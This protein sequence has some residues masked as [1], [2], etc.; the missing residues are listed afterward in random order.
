MMKRIYVVCVPAAGAIIALGVVT[1]KPGNASPGPGGGGGDAGPDV[2]LCQL[3]D[4]TS[5]GRVGDI[6]AFSIRTDTWN[7]GAEDLSWQEFTSVH[8]LMAQNLYRF[9]DGRFEQI[10]LS[11]IKHGFCALQQDGCTDCFVQD[12]CLDF[13]GVGCRDPYSSNL[14]GNQL[15]LGPRSEVNASNTE[16]P[17]PFTLGWEQT[18]DAIF[19]RIQ[20][21]DEDINPAMNPGARYFI[22]GHILHVEEG[23]SER[24]H[25]NATHEEVVPTP[26]GD[27]F[28]LGMGVDT[29]QLQPAIFA[30]QAI[31]PEVVIEVVDAPGTPVNEDGRFHVAYRVSDNGDGTWRYEY[32]VHNL[33]SHRSAQAFAVPKRRTADVIS[34]FHRDV[35]YH[36]G[37]VYTNEDWTFNI[38]NKRVS[39]SG[40]KFDENPNAN[41]LR[42]GTTFNFALVSDA[43]PRMGAVELTL[44]RPG[45]PSKMQVPALVP[46]GP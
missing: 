45:G 15:R 46:T 21:S 39:W 27:T 18:G 12:G 30:W 23:T 14:N 7:I 19:K 44:F 26:S 37:E 33:N 16:F 31:D 3:I 13:L 10:G 5:W 41:A 8:P 38:A 36:S 4:T 22:E 17:Y 2:A 24:R 43:A 40:M 35:K 6:H 28:A 1:A 20:V 9:R 32:A 25:N 34:T 29:V 42:W 11:W